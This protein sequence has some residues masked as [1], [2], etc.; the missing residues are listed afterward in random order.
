LICEISLWGWIAAAV[1]LIM[2]AFPSR[3]TFRKRPAVVWGG[4]LLF[5][6]ALWIAGMLKA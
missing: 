6:Y 5:F 4:C 2:H 1:G 3:D